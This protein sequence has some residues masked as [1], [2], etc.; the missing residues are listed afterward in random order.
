MTTDIED[1]VHMS[2]TSS[3]SINSSQRQKNATDAVLH[4]Y[5]VLE[6]AR[7][8]KQIAKSVAFE[9][10]SRSVVMRERQQIS[11]MKR[12]KKIFSTFNHLKLVT[13]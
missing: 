13:A 1:D 6:N 3:G 2:L 5:L 7:H 8:L 11:W 10:I 12:L 9:G 4:G